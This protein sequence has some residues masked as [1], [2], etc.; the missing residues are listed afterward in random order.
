MHDDVI[1]E[2]AEGMHSP[3]IWPNRKVILKYVI[4]NSYTQAFF[5]LKACVT[6]IFQRIAVTCLIPDGPVWLCG[7]T[8]GGDDGD[9]VGLAVVGCPV[10]C[11]VGSVVTSPAEIVGGSSVSS[12]PRI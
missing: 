9:F 6:W 7:D 4:L 8:V 12:N 5:L 2:Q 1:Q 3:W 11:G 10:G